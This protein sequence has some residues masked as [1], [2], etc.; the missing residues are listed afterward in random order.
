M[1]LSKLW[2]RNFAGDYFAWYP[3]KGIRCQTYK[4]VATPY[5]TRKTWTLYVNRVRQPL[6]FSS[7][8]MDV[9]RWAQEIEDGTRKLVTE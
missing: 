7:R 9:K 8:L 5:G 4:A 6:C 2:T 1:D 3:I